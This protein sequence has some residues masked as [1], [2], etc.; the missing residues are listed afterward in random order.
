MDQVRFV[1]ADKPTTRE[2]PVEKR[3][4]EA[5]GYVALDVGGR[6]ILSVRPQY[7][8]LACGADTVG[9]LEPDHAG[10]MKVKW[11]G[12]HPPISVPALHKAATAVRRELEAFPH[13]RDWNMAMCEGLDALAAALEGKG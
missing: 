13:R 5:G 9:G 7:V 4:C 10:I 11:I 1:D 3:I 6:R 2:L 12:Q 8:Y